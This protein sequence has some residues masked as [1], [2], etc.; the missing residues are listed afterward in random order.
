[1]R[2]ATKDEVLRNQL[3]NMAREWMAIAMHETKMP[4]PKTL[5]GK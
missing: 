4:H 2:A 3:F 5:I 1:M